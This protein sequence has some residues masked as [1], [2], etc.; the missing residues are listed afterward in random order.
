MRVVIYDQE[1]ARHDQQ[2]NQGEF[3]VQIEHHQHH[4]HQRQHIDQHAE[5]DVRNQT[6]DCIDIAGHTAD[7]ITGA[8]VIVIRQRQSL[9]VPVKHTPQVMHHP[10]TDAGGEIFLEVRTDG[11]EN[12]DRNHREDGKVQDR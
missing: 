5:H 9:N 10:L 2:C 7:E 3:P 1:Q 11:G 6:L 4:A 12:C 8:F